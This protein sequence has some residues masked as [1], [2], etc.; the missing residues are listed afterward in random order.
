MNFRLGPNR[1]T[2]TILGRCPRTGQLGVGIAT[3]SL[4][5]GGYCPMI[6][7]GLGALS[8]QAFA[9]PRLLPAAMNLLAKGQTPAEVLKSLADHDPYFEYRQF[10]IVDEQGRMAAH[11]G[12]KASDWKGHLIGDGFVAMGNCLVGQNV[13]QAIADAFSATSNEELPERLLKGIEA[14][15]QAGGQN[16]PMNERSAAL[17]VYETE[18]Y[19]LM[20]LRV[21]V[22][23]DAVAEL[24]RCYDAYRP[25]IPLYYDLR[26]KQPHLAPSQ[27]EW[28]KQHGLSARR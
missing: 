8:S 18:S 23:S 9:D 27:L 20:D 1:N 13:V 19:P 12:H 17:C 14:G 16:R 2:Y 28:T 3:Y 26:V 4:A 24:R 22:H 15:Q 7:S 25:Y 6:R 11:T 5:V 10:G 21:D